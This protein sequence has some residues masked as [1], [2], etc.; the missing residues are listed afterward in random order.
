MS[1]VLAMCLVHVVGIDEFT[2]TGSEESALVMSEPNLVYA[3]LLVESVTQQSELIMRGRQGAARPS[4]PTNI[5][6]DSLHRYSD[7]PDLLD[8]V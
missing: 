4:P 5:L 6:S 7:N 2:T 8:D 1:D 3:T